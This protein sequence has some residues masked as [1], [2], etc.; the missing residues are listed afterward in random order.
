MNQLASANEDSDERADATDSKAD[1]M[2][3]DV[4]WMTSRL[5][6]RRAALPW[7]RWM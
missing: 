6:V 3:A 2:T 7:Y 5:S 1:R 4:L